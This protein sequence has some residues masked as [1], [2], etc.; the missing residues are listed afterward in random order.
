ME[1]APCVILT[2]LLAAPAKVTVPEK[3]AAAAVVV[4][5]R[6]GAV[7]DLFVIVW[8]ALFDINS[9]PAAGKRRVFEAA[10]L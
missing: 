2:P 6:V 10:E 3:F 5:V 4:P 1:I 9:V 7:N 8:V